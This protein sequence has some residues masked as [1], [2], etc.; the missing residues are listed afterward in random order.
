MFCSMI[1]FTD[2]FF[3]VGLSSMYDEFVYLEILN[4]LPMDCVPRKNW[5]NYWPT[6]FPKFLPMH[7]IMS[8]IQSKSNQWI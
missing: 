5:K 6:S 7:A 3:K 1:V 4:L 8:E 2:D